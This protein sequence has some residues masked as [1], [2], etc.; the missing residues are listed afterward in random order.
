VSA[1]AETEQARPAPAGYVDSEPGVR[2]RAVFIIGAGRS[3]TSTIARGVAAL[4]VDLGER[5]KA[6]T[7]KNPTGFFEHAELLAISKQ[8]RRTIDIRADSVR[9]IAPESLQGARLEPM[10]LRARQVIRRD[11][12]RS[13]IWGFKYG[14][15]LRILPFWNP[16]LESLQVDA[17]FVIA[18]RNPLSVARS[19]A[20]LDPRRGRQAVSDLEWLVSIVPF[21]R[22]TRGQPLAVVD[23]DLLMDAPVEQLQRLGSLLQLPAGYARAVDIDAYATGFLRPGMRHTCFTDADLERSTGVNPLVRDAYRLLYRLANGA[24]SPDDV[25][26]WDAWSVIED[27]LHILAPALELLDAC[28]SERRRAMMNPL[29]SLQALSLLRNALRR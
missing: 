14:R 17:S 10:R 12:A 21:L 26:F 23:Y 4:G 29:G 7:R 3:G 20:K 6:A 18:L 15:T 8:V 11:F 24:W 25:E 16:L 27:G 5:F 2:Q 9:L 13:P 19:R 22:L 28:E 1:L